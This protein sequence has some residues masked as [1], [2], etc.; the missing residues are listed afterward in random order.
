MRA[1]ATG[2]THGA[3]NR[4]KK[5]TYLGKIPMLTNIF[6]RGWFNHQPENYYL[7]PFILNPCRLLLEVV[8]PQVE[9]IQKIG[10]IYLVKL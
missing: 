10:Y 5:K 3:V 7:H 9:K 6:Q 8:K 2:K 1:R 4:K